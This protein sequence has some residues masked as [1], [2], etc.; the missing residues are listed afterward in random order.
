M[1]NVYW[2]PCDCGER[3]PVGVRQA[4]QTI[5]CSCG[6]ELEVPAYGALAN[7]EEAAAE[8]GSEGEGLAGSPRRSQWGLRQA[9]MFLGLVMLLGGLAW[10]GYL[11]AT[12]PRL[13]PIEQMEPL[14]TWMLWQE[15]RVGADR[16]P[17]PQVKFYS[18]ALKQNRYWLAI[19]LVTA[20]LGL[21]VIGG[22]FALVKPSRG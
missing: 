6:A 4:G 7:L 13:V 15:L 14:Q 1:S 12:K 17:S 20:G 9:G 18:L 16:F 21:L 11:E 3:H 2:L 8:P 5:V 22:T 10:A 19:A